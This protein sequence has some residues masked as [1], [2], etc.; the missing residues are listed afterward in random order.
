[1]NGR[2]IVSLVLLGGIFVMEGFDI[3]AMALAVP[4]LEGALGLDP[5]GFG[6]VFTALLIGLGAGGALIAPLGD[7]FGRRTLIV[8]GCLVTGLSTLGTASATSI[9]GFLVWRLLTGL[10]LGA[11][12]PNVSALSAELAPPRLRATIMAVVSAGIPIGLA[13]AG[14]L[15]PEIVDLLG[16]EG[17]FLVPGAFAIILA[18]ALWPILHPG[19][20]GFG[21]TEGTEEKAAKEPLPQLALFKSPWVFPFAVFAALLAFNACNLYLLNS[22]LPTVLPGAGMTLDAAA[23]VT[24]VAN[25]AG[26]GIGIAAS[27]LLDRWH[28]RLTLVLL[29]GSMA[30]SFAAIW[31]TAP[32]Q[33]RWTLLLM[34]GVGGANAGGMVLPGLAAY[35]FPARMLSSAVGVGVLVARLGAFAGPPL[36]GWMLATSVAP[37]DFL[38]VAAIPAL[39][40]VAIA[41]LVPAALKRREVVEAQADRP[42]G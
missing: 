42:V 34:V 26:L 18:I 13:L 2:S 6:W 20:P 9:T 14:L 39:A 3:A 33:T 30:A 36:G 32:D 12:L 5:A 41:L 28:K 7:R 40:C 11:C 31:L 37:K 1:M 8:L 19:I 38:G 16:W 17:L 21:D 25:L 23:R 22:W 35:L 4:R 27:L 10:A 29:F 24:G 15:A